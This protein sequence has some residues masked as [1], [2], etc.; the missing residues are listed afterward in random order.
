MAVL[1]AFFGPHTQ[2]TAGWYNSCPPTK[3]I[4]VPRSDKPGEF[5]G[6]SNDRSVFGARV[7]SSIQCL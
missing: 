5:D 3:I 2:A 7:W 4:I 1:G 6:Q